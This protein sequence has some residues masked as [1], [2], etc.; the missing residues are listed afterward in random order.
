[1]RLSGRV[2]ARRWSWWCRG[3][4]LMVVAAAVAGLGACSGAP[5]SV[6][7]VA[8]RAASGYGTFARLAKSR[9]APKSAV[10][11]LV[12]SPYWAHTTF[13]GTD[14][15]PSPLTSPGNT[16]PDVSA[17]VPGTVFPP[18][19]GASGHGSV[20]IAKDV[21]DSPV[22]PMTGLTGSTSGRLYLFAAGDSLQT[23]YGV[24]SGTVITS[25][26][27]NIVVTAAHCM[28]HARENG[29]RLPVLSAEFVPGDQGNR[30]ATPYGVWTSTHFTI[31]PQW[32]H[33]V[34]QVVRG[35]KEYATGTGVG[36]DF[37]FLKMDP[38]NGRNIQD[39]T[40]AEG[41]AFDTGWAS[42]WQIGYP[43]APPFD[44]TT[45]RMCSSSPASSKADTQNLV[46]LSCTMTPGSSGG[47]YLTNFDPGTGAGYVFAVDSIGDDT[48]HWNAGRVLTRAALADYRHAQGRS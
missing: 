18:T 4:V 16:G 24:C 47:A 41:V 15:D 36:N 6:H 1:M 31:D 3:R 19:R 10:G 12:G 21:S 43:S 20:P 22:W 35:G 11:A 40:G 42:I 34:K 8:A 2:A 7:A 25:A 32:V 14:G 45:E 29:P 13:A 37:A 17:G 33:H 23:Q 5:G 27:R 28:Y 9:P 30:S 26:T 38:Q 44:G 48:G 46:W 39:V